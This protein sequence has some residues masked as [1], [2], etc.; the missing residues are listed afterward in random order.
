[1]NRLARCPRCDQVTSLAAANAWRPF[2]SERCK[3]I[4]LGQWF[5]EAHVIPAAPDEGFDADADGPQPPSRD[6]R[7]Q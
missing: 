4:D 3:L 6:Q 5:A 2:C 7:R 1:M